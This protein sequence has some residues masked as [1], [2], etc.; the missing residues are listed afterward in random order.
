MR[1]AFV[2]RKSAVHKSELADAALKV[3]LLKA[4]LCRSRAQ[5]AKHVS[6]AANVYIENVRWT[7]RGSKHK[8][9][10]SKRA[11]RVKTVTDPVVPGNQ[12]RNYFCGIS[13]TNMHQIATHIVNL[14]GGGSMAVILD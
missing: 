4:K 12:L 5:H 10:L 9:V 2:K 7:V 1:Q 13:T 11:H 3:A 14:P 6:D 8:S